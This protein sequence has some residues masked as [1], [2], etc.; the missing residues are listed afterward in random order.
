MDFRH[1]F[2]PDWCERTK[3]RHQIDPSFALEEDVLA[4]WQERVLYITCL[5]GVIAGPLALFP[6][7]WWL[8]SQGGLIHVIICDIAV[9]LF[10]LAVF[11]WKGLS[12]KVKAGIFF[13]AAYVLGVVLLVYMG[14]I[15]AGYVWLLGASILI[16]N[17]YGLKAA[18][19]SFA[20]NVVV[21]AFITG[22]IATDQLEWASQL[23]NP[24]QFWMVLCSNFLFVN[25]LVS[26]FFGLLLKSLR[27]T[28][29]KEKHMRRNLAESENRLISVFD[30]VESVSIQGYN[31]EREVVCW[32]KAS[33]KL[34]G[35]SAE[36]VMG[37]RIDD[38]IFPD[39]MRKDAVAN[40]QSWYEE[41]I[42]IPAS[43][44]ELRNKFGDTVY[45]FSS[46]V[47]SEDSEGEKTMFC[48]DINLSPLKKIEEEKAQYEEQYRQAQK[49]ESI[50]RLAGGVAHDLNNLLVPVIGYSELLVNN[51]CEADLRAEFLKNIYEAG[52]KARNLVRQLL[53]FSRK[54]PV[55]ME[56]IDLAVVVSSFEKFL[57]RIIQE[58]IDLHIVVEDKGVLIN[59]DS[60]QIEQVLMNLSVN[61]SDA[62][63]S[64]GR[65]NIKVRK[66]SIQGSS[67]MILGDLVAGEYA[68]LSIEDN[69]LGMDDETCVNIFEP[70]FSTKGTKGT[71]LGLATVYGIVQQHGGN[72]QVKSSP[73]N[74]TVFM[75]YFPLLENDKRNAGSRASDDQRLHGRGVILLVEDN[76]EVRK[77][78]NK[79]LTKSG[80]SVFSASNGYDALVL[81]QQKGDT[82]DL[83]LSDVIMPEMNGP[84]LYQKARIINAELKVL[85]MSGYT[86]NVISQQGINQGLNFINK[87][88]TE[89]ELITKIS[90]VL[91]G[92]K[93][94]RNA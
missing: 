31:R 67:K 51:L 6:S 39:T 70:F 78:T 4:F 17:M 63:P 9:Y 37:R 74:G 59:A 64:G 47:M 77:L 79:I 12:P 57:R 2:F 7:V 88:F 76:A 62:M 61:A 89:K 54:Q 83:L 86:N 44:L 15:G 75:I 34:Y 14:P 48:L 33:E 49:M 38:L 56:Q 93:R 50:G 8:F 41:D 36:E 84:E 69:G 87:P 82:V 81:M 42:P 60:N 92:E 35:Y 45:V 11:F 22:A 21:L 71:G 73:K 25:G 10:I 23:E 3:M 24:L 28:L 18:Y 20:A 90:S 16:S 55:Q 91:R 32:N 94:D 80:Y 52:L 13:C 29:Q 65:I 40:I 68:V 43:E 26:I 66:A 53:V 19:Y 1:W 30:S 72:I 58:N 5:L 27:E 46:H 85:Y